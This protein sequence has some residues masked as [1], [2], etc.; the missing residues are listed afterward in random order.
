M[1]KTLRS[2]TRS[3]VGLTVIAGAAVGVIAAPA[4]N[5]KTASAPKGALYSFESPAEGFNTKTYFYDTGKEVV[6]FDAQF[7]P[8]AATAAIA[9][10][11][12]KTKNPIT[13]VVVT[14]PNPDKFN[15]TG[16]F[17][18]E[19][20]IVV[21]SRATADAIPGV[22]T[23]KKGFFVN[24]AKSFTDATYPAQATIDKTFSGSMTLKLTGGANVQLTELSKPGVSSTQT[25]ALIPA[26][27]SIVVGD[28]VHNDAHAWLEGGIVAGSPKPTIDGWIADLN[29]IAKLVPSSWKVLGG[30]GSTA[31]VSVAIPK[32]IKYLKA[33]D[34]L[35]AT[36]VAGLADRKAA[37]IKNPGLIS[38]EL[39][40]AFAAKYP[41]YKLDY[42]ITYGV[43]GLVAQKLAG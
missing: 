16:I 15:G 8:Q 10:L 18:A 32:Q 29:Q 37:A 14:H 40:T 30:R 28:L 13:Y 25:V 11:R 20:A 36:A 35:V 22:H 3:V 38:D 6:A 2:T 9:F 4:T 41:T 26:L 17:R 34:Q 33:A 12:T 21:A 7:T 43:Y 5:A 27:S 24:V 1:M 19:G 31:T 42:M 39:T 23:Y